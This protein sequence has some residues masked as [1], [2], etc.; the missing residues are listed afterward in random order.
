EEFLKY[1]QKIEE[2]RSLDEQQGM[3]EQ[4]SQQ[5]PNLITTSARS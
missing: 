2:L 5:Q 4:S 3:M 1:A